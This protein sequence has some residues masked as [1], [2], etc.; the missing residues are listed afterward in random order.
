MN[1]WWYRCEE[2]TGPI[3]EICDDDLDNDCDGSMDEDCS[4]FVLSRMCGTVFGQCELGRQDSANN[5]WQ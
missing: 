2:Y 3:S 4:C 1:G 5:V